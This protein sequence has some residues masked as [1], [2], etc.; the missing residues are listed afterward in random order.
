LK[1]EKNLYRGCVIETDRN[2]KMRT[3]TFD[4]L[5]NYGILESENLRMERQ[6]EGYENDLEGFDKQLYE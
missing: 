5:Q 4:K 2:R 3:E 1:A 6:L